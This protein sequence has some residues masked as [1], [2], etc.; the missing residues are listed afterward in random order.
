MDP[1]VLFFTFNPNNFDKVIKQ[2]EIGDN[3]MQ[4]K[5]NITGSGLVFDKIYNRE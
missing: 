5:K 1:F 4:K 3:Y 2:P